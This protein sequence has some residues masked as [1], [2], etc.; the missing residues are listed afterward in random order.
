MPTYVIR[1]TDADTEQWARNMAVSQLAREANVKALF[2]PE[3]KITVSE[4]D[5]QFIVSID[6]QT[7]AAP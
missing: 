5:D 6:Y 2:I 1:K 4:A 7:E 3:D